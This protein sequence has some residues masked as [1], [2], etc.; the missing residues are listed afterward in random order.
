MKPHDLLLSSNLI[1]SLKACRT[2]YSE[3]LKEQNENEI[4]MEKATQLEIIQSEASEIRLK[5][6]QYKKSCK[7]LDE[8]FVELTKAAEQKNDI[9]LVIK[10]NC[11]NTIAALEERG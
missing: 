7:S 6:D 2:R 11:L 9:K 4:E 5:Q 10:D 1:R 8:E 3:F